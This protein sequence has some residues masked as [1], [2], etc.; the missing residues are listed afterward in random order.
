MDYRRGKSG[1][2]G[3]GDVFKFYG[4]TRY[5]QLEPGE[6]IH[7]QQA[8]HDPGSPSPVQE[9]T[10]ISFLHFADLGNAEEQF[11]AFG[12]P[13]PAIGWLPPLWRFSFWAR[14]RLVKS[15]NVAIRAGLCPES[16]KAAK[17]Y[18]TLVNDAVFFLPDMRDR[19][20]KLLA[21]HFEHQQL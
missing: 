10:R 7:K 4:W 20:E 18:L 6:F 12:L 17:K 3:L 11:K 8:E 16:A 19:V 9:G 21:T 13:D 2:W 14:R 15:L 5:L 1:A